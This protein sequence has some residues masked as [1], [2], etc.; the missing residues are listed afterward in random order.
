MKP[1]NPDFFEITHGS[2]RIPIDWIAGFAKQCVSFIAFSSRPLLRNS[3]FLMF[4]MIISLWEISG[5][6]TGDYR[7]NGNVDFGSPLNWERYNGTAWVAASSAPVLADGVITIRALHTAALGSAANL[8]QLVVAAGGTLSIESGGILNL[9]NGTGIDLDVSGT[10]INAGTLNMAGGATISFSSGSTYNH[11]RNGSSIP[12]AAWAPASTCEI[13]GV[14]NNA[15]GGLN[16]NFGNFTWKSISQTLN[17]A[18]LLSMDGGTVS[19]DFSI[20][21]TG[22]GSLRLATASSMSLT[23]VGDLNITGGVLNM[24]NGAGTGTLTVRGDFNMSGG[25]ITESSSGAGRIV[26]G[27]NTVQLFTKSGG[28]IS[29]IINFEVINNALL[30]MRDQVIDGTSGSFTLNPGSTLITANPLGI[31]LLSSDMTG[32]IQNAGPRNFDTGANYVYNG[33]AAQITGTGLPATVNNLTINNAAGVT[34]SGS[35]TATN[36]ITLTKGNVITG[37]NVLA[38]SNGIVGSLNYWS[39]MIVGKFRRTVNTFTGTDYLF[40]VGTPAAYRPASV[41]FASLASETDITVEFIESAPSGFASYNDDVVTLNNIYIEGYWRFISSGT[42][43]AE[44]SLS[45]TGEGF[46]SFDIN[47]IT[48]ITGRDNGNPTWRAQGSHKGLSGNTVMRQGI[49]VLDTDYFDFAFATGCTPASA[50]YAYERNIEIDYTKVEGGEDLYNFPLLISIDGESFLQSFPSGSIINPYGYDIVF[51]DEYYNK[52]DHQIE[53]Y[54]GNDGDYIAWVRIPLVS[55]VQN[56]VIKMLY[57][58]PAIT[59]DP[60]SNSVWDSE[61]RGVWHM[62]N[63]G[64]T[65][66]TSFNRPATPYNSPAFPVGPV[67]NSL[68]LNGGNQYARVSDAAN[69]NIAGDVTVSAW[70]YLNATGLDQ[71]IAGNQNGVLGGYKFGV[72]TNNRVEFEI[73]D[74]SNSYFLNRDVPGGTPLNAGQWYYVAGVSSDAIDSIKTF[75]NGIPERPYRKTGTLALS[76]NNMVIGREPWTGSYY[77]NG[78]IDELRVS[79]TVRSDGWLRTEYNN[80]SDPQ[81]FYSVDG[82]DNPADYLPSGS[83]CNVPVT[84]GYGF[85]SG[86]TYSGNP[87]ISGNVFTPPAPGS[88]TLTYTFTGA[89]STSSDTKTILVTEIPAPPLAEDREYCLGSIAYLEAETGVNHRWYSEG[90]F[91]SNANPYS[92]GRTVAGSYTYTVTQTVNGCESLPTEVVLSLFD[93]TVITSQPA[94]FISC[95][96]NSAG[97][98]IKVTGPNLKYQWRKGSVDL[99]D[100]SNI[101]GATTDSLII[102]GLQASDAGVYSCVVSSSCGSPIISNDATLIVEPLP[103][104]V[105]SGDTNACPYSGGN[106]YSITDVPGHTYVW[107]VSGGAIEGSSTGNSISVNWG[108]PGEGNV[109]VTEYV[110]SGCSVTTSPFIVQISDTVL[111][112]IT[113]CPEDITVPSDPGSC[114]AT[115]TWDEPDATDN[116]TLPANLVWVRSHLPGSTFNAGVTVVTYVVKDESDNE[117]AACTFTVTVLDTEPPVITAPP[118]ITVNNNPGSCHADPVPLGVPVTGD[119]CAVNEITNDAPA[120]FP[121]GSTTVTWTVTDEAGNSSTDIQNVTVLDNEDPVV[122]CRS[123]DAYLDA[124]GNVTITA[125]DIDNGSTDNCGLASLS[126]FP[127]S[128]TSSD[129][130]PNVVT[131]TAVDNSGNS[132]YCYSIVNVIDDLPPQAAC[133]DITIQLDE[134][135]TVSISPA[136]VDNGSTDNDGIASMSVTPDTFDCSD[137]GPNTVTLTV[138]DFW[139]NSST[140]SSVVT[141]EDAIPPVVL[142]NDYVLYLDNDGNATL[143]PGDIDNGSYDNCPS[144]LVLAPERTNFTCADTGAPVTVNLT[145]TDASGNSA[146]C[147]AF[148]TVLDTISPVV[149]ARTFELVLDASGTGT[150]L[151]SDIDDGTTDNCGTV[152]LSVFPDV[153]TCADQGVA[154]VTLSAVDQSGNTSSQVIPVTVSSTLDITDLSLVTCDAAI[155]GG[156]FTSEVQGGTSPYSYYWDCTDSE[157]NPFLVVSS[158]W[159]YY[160]FS[161]TSTF[162]TPFFNNLLPGGV[163][164]IRLVVTDVY[165][166]TDTA[167]MILN[168]TSLSFSNINLRNSEVC[169]GDTETYSV[170]L[171]P[172]TAYDWIVENGT[173]LSAEPFSN[174]VDVRWDAGT[175]EGTVIARITKTN[176][177]GNICI[178][179]VI[180]SVKINSVPVP[181]FVDPV[182]DACSDSEVTYT[183][184][185]TYSSYLWNVSGGVI[186]GGGETG[187]NFV[188]VLWGNGPSGSLSVTVT[189]SS[190]CTGS[191]LI[192]ISLHKPEGVIQSQ[193]DAL[194]Y[195]SNDGSVTVEAVTG[196]GTAPFEYSLDGNPYQPDGSFTGIEAGEHFVR[197]RDAALCI[198]DVPFTINQPEQLNGTITDQTNVACFGESTG[199]VTLNASGGVAPYEYSLDGISYQSSE[200]FE[201]L[202]AGSH[203]ITVRDD[204]GCQSIVNVVIT[205]P[206][207][208]LQGVAVTGNISCHGGANGSVALTVMGGTPSYSYLWSTGAETKDISGLIAGNYS[209]TITDANNCIEIISVNLSEPASPLS[210]VVVNQSNVSVSGGSDGSV[211]VSASGGVAPYLYRL[212]TGSFQSSGTFESL[213]AGIYTITV[214][215]NNLC[216]FIITIT[217]SQPSTDLSLSIV[218]S[219]DVMCG[220][221]STGII[222]VAGSGGTPPY[223]YSINGG[224]YQVSSV[225]GSL[226]AGTYTITVRDAA[227]STAALTTSLTEPPVLD[228]TL[229]STNNVCYGGSSGT[230]TALV[231]GGQGPYTYIWNS[232]PAQTTAVAT[233]L[234][235][236]SYTVLVTDANGCSAA[237][238]AIVGQP[239]SALEVIITGTDVLCQGGFSGSASAN[240]T[241]G[242]PPYYYSWNT[243]PVSTTREITGLSAGTYSVIVRDANGC[244]GEATITIA[245]AQMLTLNA[246]VEASSCPDTPDGS[247]S[248]TIT[249]GT[250]PY[251]IIWSDNAVTAERQNMLPGTYTV[252]VTDINAC[253]ALLTI[254][255]GFTGLFSCLRIPQIITPNND[256]YN[257]EWIIG[258]IDLYPDAEVRIYNRWGKLV[259]YGKNMLSNPWDGRSDG[260]LV[261]TDSYYYI[262]YLNDGSEP[263]SGVISVIR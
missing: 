120:T 49:T 244:T 154:I 123:L 159:P 74:A 106:T 220:G 179:T 85:P 4:A 186:I 55:S 75:V 162:E 113:G 228:L 140:C 210:G 158:V 103:D 100:G 211:T 238:G 128:F 176:S 36:S 73:R 139:G 107:M 116:C 33:S 226:A 209:V 57:G 148:I 146:T 185:G 47:E 236:G 150:L 89:C 67:F 188:T 169:E 224:P 161:N 196:T 56:T 261:P 197:I 44:Y 12:A 149:R 111:P 133:R 45:L 167:Q 183:L 190:S 81:S 88:Y 134:A 193:T 237:A 84:L 248:L 77:F 245:D 86:G 138:T 147:Q 60:S 114:S 132:N 5:Q 23:I 241:G 94:D 71:K 105:I 52:L 39:G 68:G 221:M 219:T 21:S 38:L 145:G 31:T 230:V 117:S 155:P 251:N 215:D 80:Q 119:N 76:S 35:V 172:G 163:Y 217:I 66:F 64:L 263:R 160:Q 92:T 207:Q 34:L 27:G 152:I 246:E 243:S 216:T 11:A 101:S 144:G 96:G 233:G 218:E 72:H 165:G 184:S 182:S 260:T 199:S 204:N 175:D 192:D 198:A 223:Q 157:S 104:P 83:M 156:I 191:V 143:D 242:T 58:N 17:N 250:E 24:S 164:T 91:A 227:L 234:T 51:T 239:S 32:S 26:F 90:T 6:T 82:T 252:V 205:Q 59:S 93:G 258:N 97:F 61:Y 178:S 43:S 177:A 151:P 255:V 170:D 54:N 1:L 229:T 53:Y 121:V 195:G 37:T 180:D 257:D 18:S 168:T 50:G 65:D 129:I 254:E 79:S 249:G 259:F 62:D 231:N 212:N 69:L 118:G 181:L 20:I 124:S 63:A 213:S 8:D 201:G 41:N 194:C 78:R 15:P 174:S 102:S 187:T 141:V 99:I 173:L 200:I 10:V 256:G 19:G 142:C 126:V 3:L 235:A 136:D 46:V 131:L 110:S 202:A 225:F 108:S 70:I 25:T 109:T 16:Q 240:V 40:P 137:T 206:L 9:R 29:N 7:T 125:A 262:L 98:G 95:I 214:Q 87:Y 130:G 14:I 13:T 127:D 42:P 28:E 232:V 247:V 189:S 171:L 222:E 166:C 122:L 208:P 112:V 2:L 115:V 253:A 22:T 203:N 30:D 135:G 153:F 48:R